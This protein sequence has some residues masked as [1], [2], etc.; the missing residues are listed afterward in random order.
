MIFLI[1]LKISSLPI[2]CLTFVWG[3]QFFNFIIAP[4]VRRKIYSALAL[5]LSLIINS[6]FFKVWSGGFIALLCVFRYSSDLFPSDFLEVI[7][8]IIS[9]LLNLFPLW[10]LPFNLLH[11]YWCRYHR[12]YN[13]YLIVQF[14]NHPHPFY[15]Q[16]LH[17][18]F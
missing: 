5:T 7:Y 15:P 9:I 3:L 12:I 4:A 8:V 18:Y 16:L 17:Y 11:F 1:K 14:T 10:M 2:F 6:P 13:S